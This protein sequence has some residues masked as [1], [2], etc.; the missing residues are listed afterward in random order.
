MSVAF[1]AGQR[2]ILV[3][4]LVGSSSHEVVG[5]F[6]LDTGATFTTLNEP[7]VRRLGFPLDALPR[8]NTIQTATT[9]EPVGRLTLARIASIGHTRYQVPV[10]FTRFNARL[11]IDG[12]L[13]L[14]FFAGQVLTIDF[15]AGR[16][17]LRPPRRGWPFGSW[18]AP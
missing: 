12:V 2:L 5:E 11:R 1:R 14:D 4:V 6:A 17:R 15:A 9:A 7:L 18:G 3:R 10:Q 16:I 8:S 13:G